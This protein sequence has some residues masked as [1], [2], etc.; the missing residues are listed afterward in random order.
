MNDFAAGCAADSPDLARYERVNRSLHRCLRDQVLVTAPGRPFQKLHGMAAVVFALL[1]EPLS[2]D[3]LVA[4]LGPQPADRNDSPQLDPELLRPE[5]ELE[6]TNGDD[7]GA[8][9][10]RLQV[11]IDCLLKAGLITE[12]VHW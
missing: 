12:V 8:L 4:S 11:A 5:R 9:V 3:Q 10:H 2:V 7:A 1:N 6:Q